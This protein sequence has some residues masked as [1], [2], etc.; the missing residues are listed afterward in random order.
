MPKYRITLLETEPLYAEIEAKGN[1]DARRKAR[2]MLSEGTLF[3]EFPVE[4]TEGCLEVSGVER[5]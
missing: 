3:D 2:R 1:A 5:V 4:I